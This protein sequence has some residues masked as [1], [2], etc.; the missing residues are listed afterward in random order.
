VK[1][2]LSSSSR[3]APSSAA[4]APPRSHRQRVIEHTREEILL[5]AA[6]LVARSGAPVSMTDIAAEIGLTAPALYAYFPS[7]QAIFTALIDLI[8]R[9]LD[10][11]FALRYAPAT[12]FRARLT[13]LLRAHLEGTD[14]RRDVI[15]AMFTLKAAGV[16]EPPEKLPPVI[17]VTHLE[18]WLRREARAGDLGS[19]DPREAAHALNGL[20]QGFFFRWLMAGGTDALADTSERIVELFF[21]GVAG[22]PS[23]ARPGTKPRARPHR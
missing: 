20:M 1:K 22:H 14:R 6:R 9:E 17:F 16:S 19:S 18:A 3:H 11:P 8:V 21:F 15:Q 7:K 12:P 23:P 2:P 13:T 4:A 5:A 10:G